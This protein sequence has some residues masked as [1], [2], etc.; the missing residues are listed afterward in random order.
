MILPDILLADPPW[1]YSFSKSRT[2]RVE[3]H[4]PT[5]TTREIGL[6]LPSCAHSSALFLWATAPKLLD[7]LDVMATWGFTYRTCAVWDKQRQG[8]G[9]WF[10]GQHELLLVG[11]RGTFPPPAPRLRRPS[12]I[13]VPRTAHSAKPDW[14]HEYIDIS[15]PSAVKM[16]LFARSRRPGWLAWG[17][18]IQSDPIKQETA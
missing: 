15:Y 16:E 8:M 11:T 3:N 12:V 1:R 14:V 17:N 6:L 10:R 13:R 9:Y 7:A 4:Y 5:M 2:R 18:E